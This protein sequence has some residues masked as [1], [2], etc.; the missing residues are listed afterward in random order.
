MS[1]FYG[2]S[3]MEDIEKEKDN[4]EYLSNLY[5]REIIAKFKYERWIPEWLDPFNINKWIKQH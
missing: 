1:N 2:R 5:D 4:L 3:V